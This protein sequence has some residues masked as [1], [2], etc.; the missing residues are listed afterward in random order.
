VLY[1]VACVH[2]I[3]GEHER[4]VELIDRAIDR[5]FGNRGWLEVDPDLAAI[6]GTS[7]FGALLARLGAPAQRGT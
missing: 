5:G 1:N 2:A 4:A 6:R 7:R 3:A